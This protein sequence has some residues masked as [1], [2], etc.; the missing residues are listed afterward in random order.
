[1]QGGKAKVKASGK[2]KEAP[3]PEEEDEKGD[4]LI[5]YLWT[6][7]T[8][9]THD[10]RVVNTDAVSYQSKIPE[11]CLETANRENKRKYLNTFFNWRIHFTP[12]VAS[13]DGL[14][15]VEVGATLKRIAIRLMQ[16]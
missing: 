7:G 3:P 2:G 13:V 4:L 6:Q 9:S 10:M 5:R 8:D 12:F 14:L 11:N 15:G 16:K 1:M